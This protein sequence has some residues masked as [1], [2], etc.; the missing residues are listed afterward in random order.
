MTVVRVLFYFKK[1]VKGYNYL[2]SFTGSYPGII[3][4]S[5][6]N[7]RSAGLLPVKL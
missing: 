3:F 5:K 4:L 1:T 2:L 6:Q 7:T